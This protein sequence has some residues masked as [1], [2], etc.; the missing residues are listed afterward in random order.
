MG[1]KGSYHELLTVQSH[2]KYFK[3]FQNNTKLNLEEI[4]SKR[5]F[6]SVFHVI[7]VQI[8]HLFNV[9]YVSTKFV[10]ISIRRK[11]SIETI[12]QTIRRPATVSLSIQNLEFQY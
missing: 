9:C 11:F 10:R 4:G 7:F 8:A 6:V 5:V 12:L 2:E 3:L 1:K